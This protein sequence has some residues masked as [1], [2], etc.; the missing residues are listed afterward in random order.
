MVWSP[1][2]DKACKRKGGCSNYLGKGDFGL[3]CCFIE[4]HK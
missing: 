2:D 4:L 3:L 1:Y